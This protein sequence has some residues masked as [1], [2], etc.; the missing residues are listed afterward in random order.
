MVLHSMIY[1][2]HIGLVCLFF[3]LRKKTYIKIEFGINE[4]KPAGRNNPVIYVHKLRKC[5]YSAV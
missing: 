1:R 5:Q 3:L 4:K 2:S